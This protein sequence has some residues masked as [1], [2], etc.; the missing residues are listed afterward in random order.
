MPQYKSK[1]NTQQKFMHSHKKRRNCVYGILKGMNV[2]NILREDFQLKWLDKINAI[3]TPKTWLPSVTW[4]RQYNANEKI[5]D[6]LLI[7]VIFSPK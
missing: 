3:L 1:T 4:K 7:L 6:F 5:N 2:Y